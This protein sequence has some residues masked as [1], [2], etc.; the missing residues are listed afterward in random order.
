MHQLL[1]T[2]NTAEHGMNKAKAFAVDVF[3]SVPPCWV[4]SKSKL[5]DDGASVG[6]SDLP[7]RAAVDFA[8]RCERP[9]GS[10]KSQQFPK[11]L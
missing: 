5:H 2:A 6:E 11:N 4:P 7:S 3:R 1:T 9:S 8:Q 10:P